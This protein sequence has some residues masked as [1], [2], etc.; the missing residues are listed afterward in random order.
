MHLL[1]EVA[2]GATL[3]DETSRDASFTTSTESLS[4]SAD[5]QSALTLACDEPIILGGAERPQITPPPLNI[6][7]D[8]SLL[9]ATALAGKTS[10]G[11]MLAVSIGFVSFSCANPGVSVSGG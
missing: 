10:I 7:T 8:F 3:T 4:G 1:A 2:C 9:P 6:T 5:A 11:T